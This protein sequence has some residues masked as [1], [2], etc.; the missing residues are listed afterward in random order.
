[1][2]IQMHVELSKAKKKYEI[3]VMQVHKKFNTQMVASSDSPAMK[4][5]YVW[6]EPEAEKK[7]G[8]LDPESFDDIFQKFCHI[9][10]TKKR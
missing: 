6:H 3:K 9:F 1:M 8:N 4:V 7:S 10:L 5:C 2:E